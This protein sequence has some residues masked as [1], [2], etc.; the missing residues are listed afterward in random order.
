MME[1]M[2]FG[3]I[4]PATPIFT[5]FNKLLMIMRDLDIGLRPATITPITQVDVVDY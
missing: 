4:I 2:G 5:I 3:L 1:D